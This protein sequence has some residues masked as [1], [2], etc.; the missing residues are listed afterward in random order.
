MNDP[1][2]TWVVVFVESIFEVHFDF[3]LSVPSQRLIEN[4]CHIGFV[5]TTEKFKI[6]VETL[7]NAYGFASKVDHTQ[8]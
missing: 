8:F 4:E 1:L 2:Y 3:S 6:I 7:K 5:F